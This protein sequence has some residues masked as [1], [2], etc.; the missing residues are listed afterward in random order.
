MMEMIGFALPHRQPYRIPRFRAAG[1]CP[2]VFM[3]SDDEWGAP[4]ALLQRHAVAAGSLLHYRKP[5]QRGS[6]WA[7]ISL[8]FSACSATDHW[9][10]W[11]NPIKFPL[12]Y[13][14][15][16]SQQLIHGKMWIVEDIPDPLTSHYY[17]FINHQ[18]Q[19]DIKSLAQPREVSMAMVSWNLGQ[20]IVEANGQLITIN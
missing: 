18:V 11:P 19:L 2:A 5:K 8:I 10:L 12:W 13:K 9:S 20:L 4:L 15:H 6:L 3:T 1:H 7:E 17:N 16:N 14:R